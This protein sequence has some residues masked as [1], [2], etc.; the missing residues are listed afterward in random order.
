MSWGRGLQGEIDGFVALGFWG[1]GGACK[2]RGLVGGS[3]VM[4][5]WLEGRFEL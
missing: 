3:D 4:G 5:A 2:G 1:E